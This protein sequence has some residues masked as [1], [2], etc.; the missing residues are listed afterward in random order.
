MLRRTNHNGTKCTKP[1][2]FEIEI[3]HINKGKSDP[4]VKMHAHSAEDVSRAQEEASRTE[5]GREGRGRES[6]WT[7][8]G[9]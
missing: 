3:E 4:I 2:I 9:T 5:K 7:C 8:A 1:N 6:R